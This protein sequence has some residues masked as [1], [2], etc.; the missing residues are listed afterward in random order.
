M[1]NDNKPLS[2]E[3][4]GV[5]TLGDKLLVVKEYKH[6]AD[7]VASLLPFWKVRRIRRE[8]IE[9]PKGDKQ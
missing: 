1:S 3:A 6:E 9:E 4:W 7:E 8:T 2:G 5:V